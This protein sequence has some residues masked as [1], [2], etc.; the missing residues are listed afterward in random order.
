MEAELAWKFE[1]FESYLL[2]R[3]Y[4]SV[5]YDDQHPAAQSQVAAALIATALLAEGRDFVIGNKFD[6]REHLIIIRNEY[7]KQAMEMYEKEFK[8][9]MQYYK[10]KRFDKKVGRTR[11]ETRQKTMADI[12]IQQFK[13]KLEYFERNIKRLDKEIAGLGKKRR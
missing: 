1:D 4:E 9:F 2:G 5:V 13:R 8:P 6:T 11:E 10:R 3:K 7:K 12:R